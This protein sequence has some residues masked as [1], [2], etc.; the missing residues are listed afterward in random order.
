MS[1]FAA[2]DMSLLPAPDVVQAVAYEDT[3]KAM[4]AEFRGKL[5][6]F[7][8]LLESDPVYKILEVAAYYK[9]LADQRVNDA[10]R[11][12]MPAYARGADL[13]NIAAIYGVK[14]KTIVEGD[15][16]AVPPVAPV[17]ETDADLRRRMLLAFEG[18]S[19]AGPPG[20]WVFHTLGADPDVLDARVHSPSPGQVAVTVL[21]RSNDGVASAELRQKIATALDDVRPL[22]T[23]VTVQAAAI[24]AY[25]VEASLAIYSSPDTNVVRQNAEKSVRAYVDAQ[26]GLGKSVTLSGLYAALHVQGVQNVTLSQPTASVAAAVQEAPRCGSVS[27]VVGGGDG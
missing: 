2:I 12:V 22:C 16:T 13:D 24:V 8:A 3:L 6:E 19:V 18:L 14:R 7:D 26:Y 15:A 9:T 21:S 11:A 4:I 1:G 23:Q 10:A 27:V 17:V 25:S 20:S 5:P